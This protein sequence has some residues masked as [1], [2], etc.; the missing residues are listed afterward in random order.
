MVNK[1]KRGFWEGKGSTDALSITYKLQQ[2]K[3]KS[4]VG[5]WSM[6]FYKTA[7]LL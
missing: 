1:I 5:Y 2:I 6:S 7:I 3:E 4:L